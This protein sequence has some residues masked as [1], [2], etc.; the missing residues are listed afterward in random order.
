MGVRGTES[1]WR[2]CWLDLIQG[3]FFAN[4][5]WTSWDT[6][7][8]HL[9]SAPL[10]FPGNRERLRELHGGEDRLDRDCWGVLLKQKHVWVTGSSR[11]GQSKDRHRARAAPTQEE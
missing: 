8:T 9:R 10:G 7:L 5:E 11:Q 6:N 3:L 4:D 2:A 1:P